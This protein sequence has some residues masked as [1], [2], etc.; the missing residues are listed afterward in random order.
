MFSIGDIHE[1]ES[2]FDLLIFNCKYFGLP[3][4]CV[5]YRPGL[6]FSIFVDFL[7]IF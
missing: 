7:S 5:F 2:C 3:E 4:T 1:Y 6:Y